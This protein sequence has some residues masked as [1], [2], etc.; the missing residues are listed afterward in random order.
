MSLLQNNPYDNEFTD[1]P[2]KG[3]ADQLGL[4]QDTPNKM[5]QVYSKINT[6]LLGVNTGYGDSKYDEGLNW[7]TDI[8]KD[9]VQGSINEHRANEQSGLAQAG[10]GLIRTADKAGIEMAK[11]VAYLGG[12]IAGT[13]ENIGDL[14]TGKDEHNFLDTTF[15][16]VGVK[17]LDN[18]NAKINSDLLPVYISRAVQD[19]NVIDKMKSTS[20]FATDGAD[21]L[22]YMLSAMAPGA[23]F[24]AMGISEELLGLSAKALNRVGYAKD[25]GD[26]ISKL[27]KLGFTAEKVNEIGIT[28]ANV[29]FEAGAESKGVSD[30]MMKEK[31]KWIKNRK[32]QPDYQQKV[33]NELAD[34][35]I[36]RRTHQITD[37]E[38]NQ[39]SATVSDD[40]AE[41]EFKERV[42]NAMSTSFWDNVAVLAGP[43]YIQT[44]LLYGKGAKSLVK[45]AENKTLTN[46]V[47]QVGGKIANS[48]YKPLQ[49]LGKA[50]TSTTEKEIPKLENV[51]QRSGKNVVKDVLGHFVKNAA[52]EGLWEEG[53]QTTLEN[54][55]VKRGLY[56]KKDSNNLITDDGELNLDLISL[57][58]DYIKTLG[59]TE[60]QVSVLLGA[61]QGG[62]FGVYGGMKHDAQDREKTNKLI[63]KINLHSSDYNT[64][65]NTDIYKS[66]VE[67]NK[68]TGKEERVFDKDKKGNKII[69]PENVKKVHDALNIMEG[70]SELFDLAVKNGNEQL[71]EDLK[72]SAETQLINNF[73]G[74]DEMGID[75]LHEHLKQLFSEDTQESDNTLEEKERKNKNKENRESIERVIDKAK[76][77][78]KHVQAFNDFQ[79]ALKIQPK[80]VKA[81]DNDYKSYYMNL[82]NTYI[83]EKSDEYHERKKLDKLEKQ[84]IEFEKNLDYLPK[85]ELELNPDYKEGVT[86]EIYKYKK[87]NKG[88][89]IEHLD[90]QIEKSKNNLKEI[91]ELVNDVIW[92]KKANQNYFDSLINQRE[93]L[94]KETSD[95]NTEK[96]QEVIDNIRKQPTSKDLQDFTDKLS[97]EQKDNPII[98]KA[99]EDSKESLK[100]EED[101]TISNQKDEVENEGNTSTTPSGTL[102]DN[103][104]NS[105][106][107]VDDVNLEDNINESKKIAGDTKYK[108]L[109]QNKLKLISKNQKTGVKF[110]FINQDWIDYE[111]T[112]ED[113][114]GRVL[115]FSINTNPGDNANLK[116]ASEIAT[117]LQSNSIKETIQYII[118]SP[119][120]NIKSID[121]LREFLTNYLPLNVGIKD[122]NVVAP[123]ETLP[124]TKVS[125]EIFNSKDRDSRLLIVN[126]ILDGNSLNNMSIKIAGQMPGTLITDTD[127]NGNVKENTISQLQAFQ[128][129]KLVDENGNLTK[130]GYQYIRENLFNVQDF[131]TL[132]NPKGDIETK[133][134]VNGETLSSGEFYLKIPMTNG[135]L[136]HLKLNTLKLDFNQ[137][138]LL[139][140]ITRYRFKNNNRPT[141]LNKA[142]LLK[143]IEKDAPDLVNKIKLT[144]PIE[145]D[146]IKSVKNENEISL[147]DIIDLLIYDG[148]ENE[149]SQ[150]RFDYKTGAFKFRNVSVNSL[151]ELEAV[152]GDLIEFLTTQKRRGINFGN[153]KNIG[154]K[155]LNT[156]NI[157]YLNYL[158]QNNV[159]N[160]NAVVGTDENGNLKPTFGG[161]TNIYLET[162][163]II[164]NPSTTKFTK[165]QNDYL[166]KYVGKDA[167]LSPEEEMNLATDFFNVAT[168]NEN[169]VENTRNSEKKS[170]SL[171]SQ[172]EIPGTV[173]NKEAQK[174]TEDVK[175]DNTKLSE[176]QI[177]LF[178]EDETFL[179]GMDIYKDE[180]NKSD[181]DLTYVDFEK[182]IELNY[183][184]EEIKKICKGN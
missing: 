103:P 39:K 3:L 59:T 98:S 107:Q 133:Y 34:L 25:T 26:T 83:G 141:T 71:I 28:A 2:K 31:P 172:S 7:A 147:K 9:D 95:E 116:L 164:K 88:N 13:V 45:T 143:D 90:K 33:L 37:E 61:V 169:K 166:D 89:V 77:L 139:F 152:E 82:L 132:I 119:K 12:A 85:K 53:I 15:N 6:S 158:I 156:H 38:Y 24:K 29:F 36:K 110:E 144:I 123:M 163:P 101:A 80:N 84:K 138:D 57:G 177:D 167:N 22:G 104:D 117:Y 128:T 155:A 72:H 105:F 142:T 145:Y 70:K 109:Q 165:A 42:A 131:G 184:P 111:N 68:E 130:K 108:T 58:S 179:K 118:N 136:F 43:D 100:Q 160:T 157:D 91:S 8:R 126:S 4:K 35:D 96:H 78:Q 125:A 81:N 64:I 181:N 180:N 153:P 94:E 176:P 40:V 20:F 47:D 56:G 17:A 135:E 14:T 150:F 113:K 69:I 63:D 151:D 54:R 175:K 137:A 16:N 161:Y 41:N 67:L 79:K 46:L 51:A 106:E 18:L 75:A 30:D 149:K 27:T 102:T 154:T 171:Q 48:E 32:A 124:S 92:D 93:N 55:I 19:G 50:I 97:K 168:G 127:E 44:R 74:E 21:G 174:L 159:L 5:K 183:K 173:E 62:A 10:L 76:Y 65:L 52:S 148:S 112:P 49:K 66:H 1:P 115:N 140:D 146:L 11:T 170:L 86:E 87:E 182:I 122:S 121:E 162:K 99:I 73:I 134:N 23:A 60:G 178:L 129:L 120:N 114:T